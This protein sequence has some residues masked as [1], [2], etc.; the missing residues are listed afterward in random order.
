MPPPVPPSVNDGRMIAG[1]PTCSS[2]SAASS[3]V[4]AS[5][6]RGVSR[7]IVVHRLAEELAILGLVDGVGFGADQFDAVSLQNAL[8]VQ[9]ERRVERR[10]A[11]HRRKNR[12][13][14]LLGDD[15]GDDLRRDRLDVRRIRQIRVRHDRRRIGVDENDPVALGAQRLAGLRAGIIEL[16][17]LADDDRA[18]ANDEDR[19]DIGAFGHA[20]QRFGRSGSG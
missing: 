14:P 16:A 9:R 2:A 18:G 6:E 3:R 11:A 15:L 4:W 13:R 19:F 20:A 1:R 10:L 7:P 5:L 8:L 17:G 12:I